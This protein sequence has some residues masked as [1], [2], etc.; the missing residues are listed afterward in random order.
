[1]SVLYETI[2]Q[3]CKDPEEANFYVQYLQKGR[4]KCIGS[5]EIRKGWHAVEAEIVDHIIVH[6]QWLSI[7]DTKYSSD[8][9]LA[10]HPCK[11][12]TWVDVGKQT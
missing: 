8:K 10:L 7:A 11:Q 12:R 4:I 5:L 3:I 2:L 6:D 9:I 1:M